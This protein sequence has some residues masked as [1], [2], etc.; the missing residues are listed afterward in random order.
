MLWKKFR[1]NQITQIVKMLSQ[2]VKKR[3]KI[4]S[5]AV[6]AT[7][8]LA[9][10]FVRQNWPT[11]PLDYVFPM[12]YHEFYNQSIDWILDASRQG[13]KAIGQNKNSFQAFFRPRAT[14]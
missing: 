1:E 9:R 4:V 8:H 6:F 3:G 13:V 7:P 10:K 14:W 12:I 11:W 5:A 2:R